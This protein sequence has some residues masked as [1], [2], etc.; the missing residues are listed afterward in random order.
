MTDVM[1]WSRI[2]GGFLVPSAIGLAIALPFWLW[3]ANDSVGS[4][5]GA[6]AVFIGCLAFIGREYIHV[7][8]V[9]NTCLEAGKV[10]SFEP[11]PFTRFC[12]Y[13][14]IALAQAF[15]LFVLGLSIEERMRQRAYGS[16]WRER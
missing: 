2:A 1:P 9:T 10:C 15:G 13:G 4:I 5:L 7:Q 12:I 3:K 14:F 11:E 8:R 6:G 16:E